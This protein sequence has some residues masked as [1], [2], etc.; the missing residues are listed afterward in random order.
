[1]SGKNWTAY[2]FDGPEDDLAGQELWGGQPVIDPG[3]RRATKVVL[4]KTLR[5]A[6]YV[7]LVEHTQPK[8]E[9]K[10]A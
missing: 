7:L 8:K 6:M 4:R 9:R 5:E 1:M 3:D 10:A 2:R